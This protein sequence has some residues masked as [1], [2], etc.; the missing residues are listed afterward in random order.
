MSTH[1]SEIPFPLP[2]ER[3]GPPPRPPIVPPPVPIVV[4]H[5]GPDPYERL[6]AQRRVMVRGR[7]DT[8]AAT[9]LAAELM[10]LDAESARDIEMLVN[11]PGGP[12][13]DVLG[14][15]DVMALVRGRV[16][17]TCFGQAL[18]TAAAVVAGGTGRRRA[19]A[20]AT[21][22][23]RCD[24]AETAT[25]TA[26]EVATQAAH[27]AEQRDRLASLLATATGR[28]GEEI[29]AELDRGGLLD[30]ADAVAAGVIDEVAA[31]RG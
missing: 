13:P 2:P 31:G 24:E 26:S 1:P 6:L 14:L 8:S 30:A 9:R 21:L 25:G 12:I 23:L 29:A 27:A 16:Q 11:S 22:S 10:A 18:G 3:P 19:T 5:D 20:N 28:P 4:E 17:T 7:L 15:L